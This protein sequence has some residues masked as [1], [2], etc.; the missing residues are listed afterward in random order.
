MLPQFLKMHDIFL[1]YLL[2]IC[3]SFYCEHRYVRMEPPFLVI[4]YI[5]F[6]KLFPLCGFVRGLDVGNVAIESG[7][8]FL[9]ISI[10]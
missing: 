3:R 5:I 7:T 9:F 8:S 1:V 10:I 6:R 2:I 4:T